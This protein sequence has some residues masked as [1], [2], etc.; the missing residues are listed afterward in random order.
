MM[1]WCSVLYI[2][3]VTISTSHKYSFLFCFTR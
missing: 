2:T 3:N 1:S